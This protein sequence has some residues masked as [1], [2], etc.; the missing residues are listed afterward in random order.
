MS[1]GDLIKRI[2]VEKILLPPLAGY[3]DY[4]YRRVLADFHVPFMCTEMVS[5]G[6][7]LRR[8]QK[9]LRM[10]KT[11][12]GD[13]LHGVQLFGDDSGSM[14][15]AAES[16]ESMGFDYIDINMGCAAPALIR[17]GAGVSL[18]GAPDR[19]VQVVS[20]V[21]EAV[22]VP[23]TCK[24]RLGETRVEQNALELS[25]GLVNAGAALITVHGRSGEKRFGEPV[26]YGA[27]MEIVES[28]SVPVVANGGVYTGIDALEMLS[29]TGAAAVMPGRGLIGNPWIVGEI[30]A[31]Y[32][33]ISYTGPSLAE[34][35]EVCLR[36]LGY[37]VDFVGE[38]DGVV[39]MRRVLPRYFLG[40]VHATD[41]RGSM[42][43]LSTVDDAYAVLDRLYEDGD[44]VVFQ[45]D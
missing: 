45:R 29:L 31:A 42:D 22:S 14:A 27:I 18:M 1:S 20:S 6:A 39:T 10:L 4:P 12:P 44:Q 37:L 8:N 5:S 2:R 16:L 11:P 3:T 38:R 13:H 35:K 30:Q 9:T 23:V 33:R 28:V 41:L 25:L 17:N 40:V 26:D 24:I 21:A 34:R 7:V 43:A 19:A 36:H 15:D 32:L